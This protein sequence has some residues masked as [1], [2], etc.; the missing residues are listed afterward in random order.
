MDSSMAPK[1]VP[2][3]LPETNTPILAVFIG[4]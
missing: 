1:L 4:L 3:D 2:P